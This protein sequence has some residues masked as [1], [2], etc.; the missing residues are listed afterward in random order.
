M[1][2]IPVV[3][4]VAAGAGA[5][6]NAPSATTAEAT[7]V[8]NWTLGRSVGVNTLSIAVE[9]LTALTISIMSSVG[10]PAGLVAT[11]PSSIAGTVGQPIP[12]IASAT[13]TDAFGNP[14]PAVSLNVAVTG[15]GS[16]S[17]IVTT[18]AL[19]RATVPAWTLGTIKGLNTLTLSVGSTALTFSASAA[20]GPIQALQILS[21]NNQVVLAGTSLDQPALVVPLDQYDNRLDGQTATFA[22]IAGGGSVA[23]ATAASAADGTISMPTFTLGKSDVPQQVLAT[24][25]SRT[26][27]LNAAVLTNYI[28]D[29]RFWG[30]PMTAEQQALFT[31]AAARIRGILVGRVPTMNGTGADPALCGVSGQPILSESIPGVIIYSS[32]QPIDGVG[33]ILAQAGPCYTRS[34]SDLRTAIGV[35]EFDVADLNSLA[36]GGSLQ[37]VITHEMLHVIGVGT[38][39]DDKALLTGYNTPSVSY[40]GLEGVSGCRES[41]GIA[42]CATSVPVENTGGGGTANSHW[43]ESVFGPELMTGYIN[44]GPMPI[45]AMTARS[46]ADLSY[47]VNPRASDT[48]SIFAGGLRANRSVGPSA[49]VTSM[50]ERR[51]PVPPRPLPSRSLGAEPGALRRP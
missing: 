27:T 8:G 43:R 19:G 6:S 26:A 15:G 40:V 30:S 35:M 38:F 45:S 42:S 48:Y 1:G 25:G 16:A 5:L 50:W 9:G 23:S 20:A 28:I 41:G 33:N 13:L 2:G 22:V 39:W 46:L 37:D 4:T 7:S 10:A 18:D 24:V 36:S 12:V 3:I 32:V 34:Q 44:A 14:V 51:L 29:V 17:P 47:T 21:G 31:N 49:A 11:T